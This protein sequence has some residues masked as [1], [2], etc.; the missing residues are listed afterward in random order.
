MKDKSK[1]LSAALAVAALILFL[2]LIPSAASAAPLKITES[3]VSTS[4]TA[5]NADIYGNT[6]VWKDTRN[7]GN[8][9]IYMYDIPTKKETRITTSGSAVNPAIYGSRIVWQDGRNG[10]NG[11][12]Y[13]YD[14]S[15]KKETRIT[16]SGYSFAPDIYDKKIVWDGDGILLYDLSTNKVTKII[17]DSSLTS[18]DVLETITNGNPVIY[19]NRIAWEKT[20]SFV[21]GGI[22]EFEE[23]E[24]YDLSTKTITSLG[25]YSNRF[26]PDIYKNI[27]ISDMSFNDQFW[28]YDFSTKSETV[29]ST[30]EAVS[31]PRIYGNNIV[32]GNSIYDLSTKSE[33]KIT[34]GG[35]A[36]NPCIYGDKIVWDDSR[37]GGSDIYLGTLSSSSNPL[38]ANFSASPTSGTSPLKV[39]FTDQ[40]TEIITSWNWS[41]GDGATSTEKNPTHT[42]S[43]AGNYTVNLT[44]G[45]EASTNTATKTG[46]IKVNLVSSKLAANFSASPTS[47]KAPLI[48]NFTDTSTGSPTSWQWTFGDSTSSKE[49]NPVHKYT[50]SGN[51]TVVLRVWNKSAGSS[52]TKSNYISVANPVADFSASPTYGKAPLIVNFTDKSVGMPN[53]WYWNFGDGTSSKEQNPVHKYAKSG[54][55]TVMLRVWSGT[56]TSMITKSKYISVISSPVAAFYATP[57]S[58]KAPLTVKF[59]DKSTGLPNSWYWNFGD[60]STSNLQSPTHTYT[61]GGDRKYYTVSLTV[62]NEAGVNTNMTNNYIRVSK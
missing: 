55:Y 48:V 46:Y 5:S 4:G 44:V 29:I 12:I 39:Q 51:Y 1:L 21:N 6:I 10:N 24:I 8:P 56:A 9:D 58:G 22:T 34:T 32:W 28:M 47:G 60:G 38:V 43:S 41:F 42:Y 25:S 35:S 50:K 3:Q 31:N 49:Q 15:T 61:V 27:I 11:D 23:I 20:Y 33:T 59:I 16:T 53:C 17:E 36:S 45:N 7:G 13:L 2:I 18:N 57:I 40:S 52:V 30:S 26:S 54:N 37:N 62:Q 14:L 19:G